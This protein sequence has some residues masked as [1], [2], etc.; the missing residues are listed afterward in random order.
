MAKLKNK[1]EAQPVKLPGGVAKEVTLNGSIL[2]A[3][4]E[5]FEQLFSKMF[6]ALIVG[7]PNGDN[8]GALKS[9]VNEKTTAGVAGLIN[10]QTAILKEINEQL[11][12]TSETIENLS[13]D[14]NETVINILKGGIGLPVVVIGGS[15]DGGEGNAEAEA[16]VKGELEILLSANSKEDFKELLKEISELNGGEILGDFELSI[17][18]ISEAF[19]R[20]EESA[21]SMKDA[22]IIVEGLASI[23]NIDSKTLDALLY[24]FEDLADMGKT[25]D[26]LPSTINKLNKSLAA[27]AE[28]KDI[29]KDVLNVSDYMI[30]IFDNLSE[31]AFN[32]PDFDLNLVNSM[33]M[34]IH[35]GSKNFTRS[36]LMGTVD[37]LTGEEETYKTAILNTEHLIEMFTNLSEVAFLSKSLKN[38]SPEGLENVNQWFT[39]DESIFNA[40]CGTDAKWSSKEFNEA[41]SG[42][43]KLNDIVNAL[44]NMGDAADKIKPLTEGQISNI[45]E[46]LDKLTNFEDEEG[47]FTQIANVD[48]KKF[49]TATKNMDAVASLMGN[50]ILIGLLGVLF[51]P[52][53]P[54]A[55]LGILALTAVQSL[56]KKLVGDASDKEMANNTKVAMA[57]MGELA[58]LVLVSTLCMLIG[59]FF[60]MKN[61]KLILGALGFGLVL[62]LFIFVVL[63]AVNLGARGMKDVGG[64][65]TLGEIS[66]FI[67]VCSLI[68][69]IG[70][71]FVMFFPKLII[72][73]LA[74]GLLLGIFLFCVLGTIA[75]ASKLMG[76]RMVK[77]INE[78]T[79]LIVICTLIMVLGG[80]LVLFFPQLIIGA[81]AFGLILGIFLFTVLGSIMLAGKLMGKRMMRQIDDITRL[82]VLCTLI[83]LI[84]GGLVLWFPQII[85]GAI[86]FG[87]ILSIFLV[88]VLGAVALGTKMM[89][90][91]GLRDAKQIMMLIIVCS[92][93]LLIAGGVIAAF[94]MM[95]VTIPVFIICLVGLFLG[96]GFAAKILAKGGSNLKK[97]LVIM[98]FITALV[99]AA[100]IA[101]GIIALIAA[102]T[103]LGKM[104]ITIGI[105]IVT[106]GL[107]TLLALGIGALATGP[108]AAAIAAGVAIM[109]VII[110]LIGLIG[111]AVGIIGLSLMILK[112]IAFPFRHRKCGADSGGNS[113]IKGWNERG[114]R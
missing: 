53:A 103:P 111:V 71:A 105:M 18:R 67:I 70:G 30:D 81:L 56:M 78:I 50:V 93:V 47:V 33:A 90:K 12:K 65:K 64:L 106:I 92:I 51:I 8:V 43:T 38:L 24:F 83:L 112:N 54:I 89:G 45:K 94:P 32:I 14:L 13:K 85:I 22:A 11:K 46:F 16:A 7:D 104:A 5:T 97:G 27:I 72:G 15:L 66:Q 20:V 113:S 58:K 107:L 96:M 102:N 86:I 39:S 55:L 34:A 68:M 21:E 57:N 75:L 61:P 80:A 74:F 2:G 37:V 48:S 110:V 63:G 10:S 9:S 101:F 31:V 79:E 77:Q 1:P 3:S 100:S 60:V 114:F 84:G 44:K 88:A 49:E 59:G 28:N 69:M 95:M 4:A 52:L 62:G 108:Q 25:V 26:K 82:I 23:G 41:H 29:I 73:A 40:I 36:S 91:R 99:F 76:K 109:G 98:G 17:E 6:S 87:L 35:G 42:I 19:K